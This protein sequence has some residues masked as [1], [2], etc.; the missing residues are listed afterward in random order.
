MQFAEDNGLDLNHSSI[1]FPRKMR[2]MSQK[3][4]IALGRNFW[5]LI[6]NAIDCLII[7]PRLKNITLQL[8]L[9]KQFD[10]ITKHSRM[11]IIAL[12]SSKFLAFLLVKVYKS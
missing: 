4:V 9:I 7:I 2:K 3:F 5:Q 12:L 11:K 1:L 6:N 10:K 8:G